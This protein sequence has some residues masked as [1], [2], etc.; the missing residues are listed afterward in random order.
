MCIPAGE[1]HWRIPPT[2]KGENSRGPRARFGENRNISSVYATGGKSFPNV[3]S[4]KVYLKRA[5]TDW[6]EKR[7]LEVI[8]EEDEVV[9]AYVKG[10]L[11]AGGSPEAKAIH[12]TLDGFLGAK[13]TGFVS[14]LWEVLLD[15]QQQS[16]GVPAALR[17]A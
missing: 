7:L 10:I 2:R 17:Q 4:H 14:S 15:A 6:A 11:Q 13:T 1:R 8:G 3:Y 5:M 12:V 9:L 16:D